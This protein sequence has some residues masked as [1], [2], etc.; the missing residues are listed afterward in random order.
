MQSVDEDAESCQIGAKL[1]LSQ[2]PSY[3]GS[4]QRSLGR[5][6]AWVLMMTNLFLGP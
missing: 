6:G 5:P 4:L 1:L 2:K 3:T